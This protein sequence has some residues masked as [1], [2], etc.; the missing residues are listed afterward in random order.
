MMR[1]ILLF[2]LFFISNYYFSQCSNYLNCNPNSGLY[3]G[4]NPEDIEYD[5]FTLG[6]HTSFIKN[7]FNDYKIWGA[8]VSNDGTP[9]LTPK[10][11]N[12]VN[13]PNLTG[14]IIKVALGSLYSNSQ[15]IVLTTDGLF[16]CGL[17]GTV[18]P[19]DIKSDSEFNKIT[20]DGKTDG[21]PYGV[22]PSDVKMIFASTQTLLITTCS[23]EVFV[24]SELPEARGNGNAG[25][26]DQ[27][28][29]VMENATTPLTNVIVTR[30][31]KEWD[32]P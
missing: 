25:T 13:Y 23:G 6:Y 9:V 1:K 5:N 22:S 24:L 31:Q 18:I 14:E 28:H 8:D 29:Q 10:I 12:S 2:F 26:N 3:S 27:W 16:A 15:L 19:I 30:G 11:I 4:N 17:P 21:L 7:P 20:V 32:M